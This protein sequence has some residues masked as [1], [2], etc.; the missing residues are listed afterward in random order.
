MI[1]QSRVALAIARLA[2]AL[3]AR[4]RV[5]VLRDQHPHFVFISSS[6]IS[7][8]LLLCFS[9]REIASLRYIVCLSL[10]TTYIR[11]SLLSSFR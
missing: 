9:I 8:V 6:I 11:S 1:R 2:G 5:S 3:Q 10:H 7:I 4:L